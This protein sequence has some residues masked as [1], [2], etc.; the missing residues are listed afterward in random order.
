MAVTPATRVRLTMLLPITF[1]R[2]MAGWAM[3]AEL[4]ATESS[5]SEVEKDM[6]TKP[7][8]NSL[9]RRNRE[10][11]VRLRTRKLPARMSRRQ[12]AIK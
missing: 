4:M 1:P 9:R 12:D 3:R 7:T 5:G 6:R 10:S 2:T 8:M 11:A